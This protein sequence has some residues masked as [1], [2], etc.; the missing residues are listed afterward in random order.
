MCLSNKDIMYR[1]IEVCD[2]I[3]NSKKDELSRNLM[4]HGV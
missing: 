4:Q 2:A 1:Y 3:D